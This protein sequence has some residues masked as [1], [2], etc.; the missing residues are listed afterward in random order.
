[1]SLRMTAAWLTAALLGAATAPVHFAES[2]PAGPTQDPASSS[3]PIL[4][5]RTFWFGNTSG[6]GGPS[7]FPRRVEDIVAL[8]DG[9]VVVV[10]MWDEGHYGLSIFDVDADG[11]YVV[12]AEE[13]EC[14]KMIYYRWPGDAAI[15]LA[16]GYTLVSL[17]VR[18]AAPFTA[19]SLAQAVNA[20]GGSCAAVVRYAG[21]AFETHPA[22]TALN[23]F[24]IETGRGYFLRCRGPSRWRIAGAALA[25]AS[26]P[27][28]L[29]GGYNLIG[30]PVWTSRYTAESAALDINAGGGGA[31]Q[32]IR[33]A[34]GLFAT[35]PAGTALN[36][37][38]LA[39]GEGYFIR[40]LAPSTWTVRR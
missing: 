14:Q 9:G 35:H 32:V 34:D 40:C 39:P 24:A 8:P 12:F 17:P 29:E 30:L 4:N 23:N 27:L 21:G 20:Q 10:T 16:A 38:P 25:D 36:N 33:Y 22:G 7:H 15:Q 28:A 2:S 3:V 5:D 1:M 18:P 31:T 19:E 26:A 11:S 13:D 6:L 37:F